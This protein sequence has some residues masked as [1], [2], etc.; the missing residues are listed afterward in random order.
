[1]PRATTVREISS[2][3]RG[4]TA[5]IVVLVTALVSVFLTAPAQAIAHRGQSGDYSIDLPGASGAEGIAAGPGSIAY[6][7]DLVKGDI[8]RGDL[9]TRRAELFIDAP[10]GRNAVGMKYDRRTRLLF[11]AGGPTG[12]A[13]VYDTRHGT[14]VADFDLADG[15][16]NDVT[17]TRAGA[18]FT[19]SAAGELYLLPFT[20]RGGLGEPR[21][22]TL[23]G[24]AAETPEAF[25]LNGIASLKGGR[26][27]LVAHSANQTIYTVNPRTGASAETGLDLPNVDGILASGSRVWAV[28]NRLNQISVIRFP[29]HRHHRRGGAEV[30]RIITSDLFQVPTTVARFGR[31][32][33]LP[34]AKFGLPDVDSYDVVVVNGYR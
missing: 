10:D 7:G 8:Y 22:L 21:T 28:Q 16:I 31:R 33:A 24:P 3:R 6:A 23:T 5:A 29:R 11:V 32:L 25:N 9:R 18:W 27:L 15:F 1:M 17:L 12:Q 19:N 4:L 2:A 26:V 30:T 14:P 13:Y 20:R 34:N